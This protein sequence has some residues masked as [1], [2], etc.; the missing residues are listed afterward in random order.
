MMSDPLFYKLLLV[1]LLWLCLMLHVMWPDDR[2][3]SGQQTSLPAKAPRKRSKV[4]TPFPGLTRKPHCDA[5]EDADRVASS[6]PLCS[7]TPHHL[8]TRPPRAGGHRVPFLS[9]SRLSL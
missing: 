1:G 5:C 8:H 7:A 9:R 3:S 2:A 6:E 4:S